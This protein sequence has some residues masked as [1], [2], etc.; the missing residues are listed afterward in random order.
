MTICRNPKSPANASPGVPMM[1]SVEVSAETMESAIAH[2]G[3]VRIGQKV[4]AQ[5]AVLPAAPW[6]RG[7][8]RDGG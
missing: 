1:V 5:R 2:H 6:P 4:A 7:W 3:T 8:S